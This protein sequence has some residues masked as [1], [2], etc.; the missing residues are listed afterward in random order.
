MKDLGTIKYLLY[1]V[2]ITE[3]GMFV[4]PNEIIRVFAMRPRIQCEINNMM[5][6]KMETY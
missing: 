1:V 3:T 5:S 6:D 4:Y 2:F